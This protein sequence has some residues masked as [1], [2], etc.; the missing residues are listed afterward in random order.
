LETHHHPRDQLNVTRLVDDAHAADN[1]AWCRRRMLF[2][3]TRHIRVMN[4]VMIWG[5]DVADR[6]MARSF[7]RDERPSQASTTDLLIMQSWSLASGETHSRNPPQGRLTVVFYG[8][9]AC[10][11]ESRAK[12]CG[13]SSLI[14]FFCGAD[15]DND[16]MMK[17]MR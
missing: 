10:V 8:D 2:F 11:C 12:R 7:P 15:E 9:D 5:H 6:A 17:M 3:F 1:V 14:L 13:T 16:M 4:R